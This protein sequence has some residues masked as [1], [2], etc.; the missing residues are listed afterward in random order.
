[1]DEYQLTDLLWLASSSSLASGS[2]G[3][4]W[5]SHSIY[6][7]IVEYLNA[8]TSQSCRTNDAGLMDRAGSSLR[9]VF[10]TR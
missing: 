1:M 3:Q 8:N 5:L 2:D 10:A 6:C 9:P 4:Q 7:L